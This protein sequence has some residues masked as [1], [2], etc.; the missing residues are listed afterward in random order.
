[1]DTESFRKYIK[2]KIAP[3]AKQDPRVF[4]D[5]QIHILD[6]ERPS[7]EVYLVRKGKR[8]ARI[9][10]FNTSGQLGMIIETVCREWRK[11]PS[12]KSTVREPW[13]D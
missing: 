10:T 8:S 1:M 6:N 9:D 13:T 11:T 3:F 5:L 4:P 2:N 12:P 7:G